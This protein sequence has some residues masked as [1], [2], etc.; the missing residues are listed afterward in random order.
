[1]SLKCFVP[2]LQQLLYTFLRPIYA[3]YNCANTVAYFPRN[4]VF[5][6][7]SVNESICI[8][9]SFATFTVTVS[10]HFMCKFFKRQCL[11]Y[12]G[13]YFTAFSLSRTNAL[14]RKSACTRKYVE[15]L[16]HVN[17]RVSKKLLGVKLKNF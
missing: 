2:F 1:M 11:Q 4:I 10:P 14:L 17:S 7:P 9:T 5:I 15:T 16:Q 13:P 6:L 12:V 3:V 8:S